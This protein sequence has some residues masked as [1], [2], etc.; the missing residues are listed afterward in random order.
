MPN[1]R[2][3]ELIG[4][5][6]DR[7]SKGRA[8]MLWRDFDGHLIYLSRYTNDRPSYSLLRGP[9]QALAL[10]RWVFQ[11]SR[12]TLCFTLYRWVSRFSAVRGP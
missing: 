1:S 8:K 5:L 2:S 12:N 7:W 3:M 11:Y 6:V 9:D 10:S 4:P